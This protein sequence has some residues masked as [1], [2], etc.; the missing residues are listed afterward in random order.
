MLEFLSLLCFNSERPRLQEHHFVLA[1]AIPKRLDIA[2]YHG[3]GGD[4][5]IC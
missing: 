5:S 4:T 2:L 3:G 1:L